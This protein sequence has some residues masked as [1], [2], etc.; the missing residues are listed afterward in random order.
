MSFSLEAEARVTGMKFSGTHTDVR[1]GG[2]T[3]ASEVFVE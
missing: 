3:S 2:G 1:E